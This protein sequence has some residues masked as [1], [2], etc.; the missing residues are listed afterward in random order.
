MTNLAHLPDPSRTIR[1]H[2]VIGY[3]LTGVLI[4]GLGGWA[5]WTE[6]VGAVIASGQVVVESSVK[7]IQ[8]PTGGIVG[9]IE[10]REGQLV[11]AGDVVLRLDPTVPRANLAIIENSLDQLAAREARLQA[12]RDGLDS[13][14]MPERF[15]ERP[16]TGPAA[17]LLEGER[18][19]FTLRKA[20][21]DGQIAQLGERVKQ[22]EDEI[23]GQLQQRQAKEREIELIKSELAGVRD[24]YAKNLVPLSRVTALER[25]AARLAGERGLLIA[26]TASASGKINETRL[27]ILQVDQQARGDVAKELR[28]LQDKI[29]ELRERGVAATDQLARID[30]RAPQDGTV[31]DLSVFTVGGVVN[32]GETVMTIVPNKDT[33]A[34]DLRINPQD[35]SHIHPD[36][37]V[38]LRVSAFDQRTTPEIEGSLARLGAD[39]TRDE[40][41]G[42]SFYT[43]RVRIPAASLDKLGG[44]ALIPGM[45]V[46]A[47]LRTERRSVLSYLTKPLTDQMRRAFRAG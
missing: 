39:V 12:E 19:L 15:R 10:V 45:P 36:Q 30:L 28:E 25:D 37:P 40:R 17:A 13:M 43:A 29:A 35:I 3:A 2:F 5:V 44:Q 26:S 32:P 33:L 41:A 42:I 22:L 4:F 9:R 20:A 47:F 8:H 46:E 1:R 14:A 21:R 27:Q 31:H 16:A 11:Q 34:A 23:Q 7:K 6:I 18:R 24:L 38:M